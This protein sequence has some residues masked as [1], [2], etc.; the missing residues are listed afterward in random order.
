[1]MQS[2]LT[3]RSRAAF[4]RK[5]STLRM[6]STPLLLSGERPMSCLRSIKRCNHPRRVSTRALSLWRSQ[7]FRRLLLEDPI[8]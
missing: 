1:M 8:E 7:L 6:K 2:E 5:D 4:S 3:W